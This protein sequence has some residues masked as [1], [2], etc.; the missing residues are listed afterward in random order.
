MFISH[1]VLAYNKH[2]IHKPSFFY[3]AAVI[4]KGKF[5]IEKVV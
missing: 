4:L 1:Y 5:Y 3:N 2:C